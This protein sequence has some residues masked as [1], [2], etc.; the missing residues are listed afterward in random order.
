MTIS[1][2]VATLT[3]ADPPVDVEVAPGVTL[4]DT[5]A[6]LATPT[7]TTAPAIAAQERVAYSW[8]A[9]WTLPPN[10]TIISAEAS[11]VV[12]ATATPS[13]DDGTS[14]GIFDA[15]TGLAAPMTTITAGADL[16]G[17]AARGGGGEYPTPPDGPIS[18]VVVSPPEQIGVVVLHA[19]QTLPDEEGETIGPATDVTLTLTIET[20][21]GYFR[22]IGPNGCIPR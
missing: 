1:T 21:S 12:G 5:G 2:V 11:A 19:G 20:P 10:A 8:L 18:G 16:Y 9:S 22:C 7:G 17:S 14:V 13:A 15:A 4:T 3:P 6:T